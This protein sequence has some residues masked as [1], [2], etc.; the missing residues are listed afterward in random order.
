[1][2]ASCPSAAVPIDSV[3]G[4]ATVQSVHHK[5]MDAIQ[6]RARGEVHGIVDP[7]TGEPVI[8]LE[9]TPD[10]AVELTLQEGADVRGERVGLLSGGDPPI[11]ALGTYL[12]FFAD[13]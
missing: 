6:R 5:I 2:H 1:M 13:K 4:I 3:A 9:K 12:L 11:H 10:M 7:L 8:P